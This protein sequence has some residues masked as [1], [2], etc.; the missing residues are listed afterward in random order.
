A[1]AMLPR[2]VGHDDVRAWLKQAI[3][4]RRLAGGYLFLGPDGIGK[5]GVALEFAAALRC[6]RGTGWACGECG[7][8][9]RIAKDLH[10]SVRRFSKPADKTAFPVELVR[11]IVD[12]ASIR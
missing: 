11:D 5:S 4:G 7:E 2:P 9:S 8:C 3:L 1:A 12:E 10:P 6:E